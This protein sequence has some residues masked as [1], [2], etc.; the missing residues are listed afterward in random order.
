MASIEPIASFINKN[1]EVVFAGE[2]VDRETFEN[3]DEFLIGFQQVLPHRM[4]NSLFVNTYSNHADLVMMQNDDYD[5]PLS[6]RDFSKLLTISARIDGYAAESRYDRLNTKVNRLVAEKHLLERAIYQSTCPE[7]M[8]CLAVKFYALSRLITMYTLVNDKPVC[9][10]M[11]RESL[12]HHQNAILATLEKVK[13]TARYKFFHV[14]CFTI[15]PPTEL[16][17]AETSEQ[18]R[19][20]VRDSIATNYPPSLY[21]EFHQAL[22]KRNIVVLAPK[23]AV[24]EEIEKG[25]LAR[26]KELIQKVVEN[27]HS[28]DPMTKDLLEGNDHFQE[29]GFL[30]EAHRP[31]VLTG[32]PSLPDPH[33]R[34]QQEMAIRESFYRC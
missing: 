27:I 2:G 33:S 25:R 8:Y 3:V 14:D 4:I 29:Y 10:T 17:I 9:L 1:Y 24:A 6:H 30:L 34:I 26:C 20:H 21:M 18:H 28:N 5:L 13:S 22:R 32:R 7:E 31:D 23:L 15:Y 12:K 16:L 11:E 19:A